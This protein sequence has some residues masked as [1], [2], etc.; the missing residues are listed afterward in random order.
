MMGL[1]GSRMP[2]APH[3]GRGFFVPAFYVMV[4]RA[5]TGPSN[6]QGKAVST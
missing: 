4:N 3:T 6:F 2:E 1:P 5:V